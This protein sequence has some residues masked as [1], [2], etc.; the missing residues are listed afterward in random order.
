MP[1][2][3]LYHPLHLSLANRSC[4]IDINYGQRINLGHSKGYTNTQDLCLSLGLP[5]EQMPCIS[6]LSSL[7][8]GLNRLKSENVYRH[9]VIYRLLLKI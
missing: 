1:L 3:G 6:L 4:S 8:N 9:K 5:V 2:S 7:E